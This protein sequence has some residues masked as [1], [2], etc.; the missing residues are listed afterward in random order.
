MVPLLLATCGSKLREVFTPTVGYWVL[1]GGILIIPVVDEISLKEDKLKIL[2]D[3]RTKGEG[4]SMSGHTKNK[5][6][7]NE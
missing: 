7:T 3:V 6:L 2:K 5:R 1:V 4:A